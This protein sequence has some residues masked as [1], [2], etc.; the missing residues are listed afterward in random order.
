MGADDGDGGRDAEGVR[1]TSGQQCADGEATVAPQAVDAEGPRAPFGV[2][3]VAH[4]RQQRRVDHGRSDPEQ[5]GSDEPDSEAVS[6]S[7]HPLCNCLRDHPADDQP[8]AADSVGGS[9]G[10]E[11]AGTPDCRVDGSQDADPLDAQPGRGKQDREQS[12]GQTVVEV[13]DQICLADRRQ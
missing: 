11:L 9:P 8:F 4:S 6:E 2:G 5:D 3:D 1:E 10:D 12:P 7:D 13:V